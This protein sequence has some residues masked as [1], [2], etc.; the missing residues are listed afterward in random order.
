MITRI[1][2]RSVR[3][4]V[5]VVSEPIFIP[6]HTVTVTLLWTGLRNRLRVRE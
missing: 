6:S 4:L 2:S 3:A 5:A 1:A